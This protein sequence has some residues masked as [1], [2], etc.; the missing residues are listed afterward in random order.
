MA[1]SCRC[2]PSVSF[3]RPRARWNL[4]SWR[5]LIEWRTTLP[6]PLRHRRWMILF[7]R[8]WRPNPVVNPEFPDNARDG[9][10]LLRAAEYVRM[11]TDHQRYS[12]ENQAA[13]IHAYAARRG[14]EIVRTFAD[15]GK[16]GLRIE[17]RDALKQ[18]I[19][20]VT[21]GSADFDVSRR[22]CARPHRGTRLAGPP[23]SLLCSVLSCQNLRR[24]VLARRHPAAYAANV[25]PAGTCAPSRPRPRRATRAGA[26]P[27]SSAAGEQGHILAKRTGQS[28]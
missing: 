14:M 8:R 9:P 21:S 22:S 7:W 27:T 17:G 12:T 19:E 13:A 18:L 11:S 28:E 1:R 2:R 20:T 23:L 25:A 24:T 6:G 16:S 10:S 3:E 4:V 15:E 26:C 5:G